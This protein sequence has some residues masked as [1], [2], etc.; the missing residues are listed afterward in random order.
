MTKQELI[1]MLGKILKTGNNLDFLSKLELGEGE[2]LIACIRD[3][4]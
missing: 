4:L 1:D 3:R 2:T